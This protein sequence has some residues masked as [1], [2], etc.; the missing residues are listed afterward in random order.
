[1]KKKNRV[2]I[3]TECPYVGIFRGIIELSRELKSLGFRL[4]FILPEIPRNRYGENQID[5]EQ[6]LCKYGNII[7]K[8]LRRKLI[9]LLGD[10]KYL[11]NYFLYEKPDIVISYTEYAGKVCRILRRM[12]SINNLYHTPSCI[13]IKR[14][15]FWHGLIE[16]FFE[17]LLSTSADY[18]LACGP[19]ECFILNKTF[20]VSLEKII[21]LPDL[22]T[23]KN[24]KKR[25]NKYLFVYVG[26]II[27]DK[28]VFELL[29]SFKML[30]LLE[31]V[32]FVGDGRE[33]E[34][35]KKLYPTTI[36]TGRVSPEKV[37]HYLSVSKYFISNSVVEGMPYTLVE[38]MS[39]G[40]VPIVS[41]V[42]GH[43]DLILNGFN[44]FLF[45]NQLELINTI[46]KVQLLDNKSYNNLSKNAK[47]SSNKLFKLAKMKIKNNFNKYD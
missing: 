10:I 46:F 16:Y 18:Y 2:Y 31:R 28:G 6:E 21:F 45:K 13:G 27:K 4:T 47:K 36:F 3:I 34:K 25:A 17:K 14:K 20:K 23:I 12:G 24:T 22:R 33:L 1:M 40:A 19:S 30:N 41:N 35:L 26:R 37:L 32:I 11:N 29:E 7:H 15:S 44:G 38:A 8:P 43:A 5:N 42:E 39:M 9:F